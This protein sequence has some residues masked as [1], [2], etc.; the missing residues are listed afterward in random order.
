MS[1][2]ETPT[3]RRWFVVTNGSRARAWVQRL[4][5][6]GYDLAMDWDTPEARER[7]AEMGENRSGHPESQAGPAQGAG[8]EEP[9]DLGRRD[10]VTYLAQ[11]LT[12]AMRRGKTTGVVL[13]APAQILPRLKSALPNDVA[14]HVFGD[15]TGDWTQLPNGELFERLDR[16][17]REA[18]TAGPAPGGVAGG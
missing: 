17:R 8:E 10:H 15:E 6:R 13:I 18:P 5:G 7:E 1:D 2:S 4:G 3:I 16:L 12:D 9:K 14:P 11:E